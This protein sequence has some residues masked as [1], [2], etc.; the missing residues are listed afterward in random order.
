MR[1]HETQRFKSLFLR[2]RAFFAHLMDITSHIWYTRCQIRYYISHQEREAAYLL[3]K[4][5]HGAD[6]NVM[7]DLEIHVGKMPLDLGWIA[8][9][10]HPRSPALLG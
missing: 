8:I 1:S 9:P 3:S 7:G 5:C 4:I 2:K 6:C 10:L